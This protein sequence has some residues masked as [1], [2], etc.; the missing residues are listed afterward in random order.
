MNFDSDKFWTFVFDHADDDPSKLRL[1]YRG[2]SDGID[3]ALAI[4]QIECRRRYARKTGAELQ[5]FPR[6]LFANSL[7][8]EQSTSDALA[9][10][11]ATLAP[12]GVSV[13]DL[14]AGLGIDVFNLAAKGCMVTAVERQELLAE[15]LSYNARGLGLN[16]VRVING[17]STLLLQDGKLEADVAF[18]DPARRAADGGRVFALADCE[19]DVTALL[20]LLRRYFR[21]LIVK[22]S[23]M[24]DITQTVRDLGDGVTDIY[25]IGTHTECKEVVVCVVTK[26]SAALPGP[27]IH[28][29]T[30]SD[31]QVNDFAFNRREEDEAPD[32]AFGVPATGDYVYQ[33]YPAVMKAA[34][35]KQL[36]QAFPAMLKLAPNAHIYYSKE[37]TE[38]FPGE[39]RQVEAVIPW[40][41]KY[42]KRL[43]KEY[44]VRDIAVRNFG[45]SADAL[46]AKLGAVKG[47]DSGRRLLAVT[48]RNGD[49]IMLILAPK[50]TVPKL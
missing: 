41:S 31:G 22:L 36:A 20:P 19:P 18:I 35:F 16:N 49:R 14:T 17:D 47:P 8:G 39:E 30:L 5:A 9:K 2:A 12:A 40:Q 28:A 26:P 50:P 38:G 25:A 34:P 11:H 7:A 3:Y 13:C 32:L 23:P 42:I 37:R 21:T 10:F 29:V 1:K 45:M 46:R 15:A 44:A 4:T 24:L 48:N 43:Q 33:P 6:F 27:Q